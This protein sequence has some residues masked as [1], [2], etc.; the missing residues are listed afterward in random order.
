MAQENH[1]SALAR[2][3]AA[4]DQQVDQLQK[5]PLSDPLTIQVLKRKK[6]KIKDR[7]NNVGE[8]QA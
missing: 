6:L 7:L 4:L 3:H 1:I 5:N 2:K 8:V